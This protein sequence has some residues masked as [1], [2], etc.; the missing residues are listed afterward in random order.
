MN[1]KNQNQDH[2]DIKETPSSDN[3]TQDKKK[4]DRQ[5][6]QVPMEDW[7][8][9]GLGELAKRHKKYK[10]VILEG[11]IMDYIQTKAQYKF[12]L[13]KPPKRIVPFI[14]AMGAKARS[15]WLSNEIYTLMEEF[16]DS[17]PIRVN[18]VVYSALIEGLIKEGIIET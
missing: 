17:V 4:L 15:I 10:K 11:L 18:R 5:F 7:A 2:D 14:A 9:D 13:S 16:A 6:L 3:E 1:V 8:F 12:D